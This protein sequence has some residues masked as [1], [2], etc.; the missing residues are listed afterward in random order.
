MDAN[1]V[2]TWPR[3]QHSVDVCPPNN[4]DGWGRIRDGERRDVLIVPDVS[5][6]ANDCGM[7]TARK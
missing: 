4:G 6:H 2:C 3:P 7:S 5:R 1:V